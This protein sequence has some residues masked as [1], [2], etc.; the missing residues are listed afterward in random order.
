MA[1]PLA[2][3]AQQ[4]IKIPRVGYLTGDSLSADLPRRD[5]FKQGLRELGYMEGQ[6]ILIDYRTAD[7]NVDQLAELAAELHRLKADVLFAFTAQ[8][9]EAVKNEMPNM[10]IVGVAPDLVAQRLV[11]SLARPGGNIT[12]LS[13][14]AGP[15]IYGKYLELLKDAAPKINRIAFLTNPTNPLSALASKALQTAAPALGLLILPLEAR[16]PDELEAA[17]TTATQWGAEGLVVM[18]DPMFLSQR[19]Q[20]AE[21]ASND[22]LPAIYGITDHARAGGLMAYAANRPDIFRRAATYVDKILKGAK[23]SDLP[24]EQPTKF[25]LV[26]NLK[27]AK[28]LGLAIPS[29]LLAIADEVIE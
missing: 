2:A 21:L 22:H 18:Q 11:V 13:T 19:V 24:V 3:Y 15:E 6:N 26:I 23:P 5:A 1:W 25:E 10:P 27:A 16:R 8:A 4:P 7:G 28:A 17:F 20:L 29:I 12:G 9:V 14:T